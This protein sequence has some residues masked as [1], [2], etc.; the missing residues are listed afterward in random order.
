VQV[1]GGILNYNTDTYSRNHLIAD[2]PGTLAEN[3]AM[4]M[5]S[6]LLKLHPQASLYYSHS[7]N[8]SPII[9]NNTALW[10]DG[11][12]NEFGIK[13]EFFNQRLS[14]NL[15][16]FDIAQ[17]NV[18]VPNPDR[19]TDPTAPESLVSDLKNHGIEFELVGGI[20][21]NL[22]AIA[23]FTELK[24]RDSL[25]RHVRA[26]AERN[27]AVL[28]NY[29]F[30]EGRFHGLAVNLGISYSGRRAGDTPINFT[31][32]NVVGQTSFFLKPYYVT[33]LG[34]SYRWKETYLFRLNI[35]NFLD[36]KGYIQ[37]AGGRVSG[38]GITTAPGINVKFATTVSF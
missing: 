4:W 7:T 33:T 9:A 13:T 5:S 26:V 27:G 32:L 31:P 25:G 20:T 19:Q 38:T 17:T 2:P 24:M 6:V 18:T 21:P 16:Y 35:D 23:T 22:S 29:R 36:D 14:L 1:T 3:K 30:R 15:A 28:L 10:R 12:Q 11:V 37:Q 8:S 34:A